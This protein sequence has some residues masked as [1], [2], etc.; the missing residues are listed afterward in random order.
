MFR[1]VLDLSTGEQQIIT[2]T[3]EE[4]AEYLASLPPVPPPLPRQIDARRLRLALLQL[5]LLDTVEAALA[6]LCRAAQIEWEYA[7]TITEDNALV[8][9]IKNQ[10]QLDTEAIIT[11]ALS[12]P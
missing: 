4:E 6:Q 11:L 12:L 1:T 5:N 3:E 2:F 10:L 9:A 7:T 8:V